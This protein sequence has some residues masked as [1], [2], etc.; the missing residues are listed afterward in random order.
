MVK[1]AIKFVNKLSLKYMQ[2]LIRNFWKK[3]I[4]IKILINQEVEGQ[5]KIFTKKY[6]KNTRQ[7]L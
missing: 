1:N 2:L 4:F 7:V 5:V 3:D 6:F